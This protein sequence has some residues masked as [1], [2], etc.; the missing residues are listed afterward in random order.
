MLEAEL[1]AGSLLIGEIA[2]TRRTSVVF[3][4]TH[5]ADGNKRG[6]RSALAFSPHGALEIARFDD[7][8]KYRPLKTAPSL[9]RGW[10]ID[11][12][13]ISEA[14]EVI[15]AIYPARLAVWR[16]WKLG[17]LTTTSLR[18]TLNR[19][20]GMYRVAGKI[21]DVQINQLVGDFC[22]SDGQ[23]LRTILWRRNEDG[24]MPSR[25]LPP[26][27]FDP[28]HNQTGSGEKCIPLLCQEPCNLLVAACRE[29]VKDSGAAQ[30]CP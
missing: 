30:A 21:S 5:R 9:R 26:E 13:H 4:L 17:Q 29:V 16:A 23:C 25:K 8:G 27:K 20:S 19:Q 24:Q 12:P 18:E 1:A 11:V 28:A 14:I 2:V 15:D 3:E 7:A 10:K 6:V 22:R